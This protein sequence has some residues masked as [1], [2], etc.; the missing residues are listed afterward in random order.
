MIFFLIRV[1]FKIVSIHVWPLMK[2]LFIYIKEQK[3]QHI[4]VIY[5]SSS[6]LA[7][8]AIEIILRALHFCDVGS[9]WVNCGFIVF[10][11]DI[12]ATRPTRLFTVNWGHT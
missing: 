10:V 11:I 4:N 8:D 6:F 2:N 7:F 9:N 12:R 5:L 1:H 3:T